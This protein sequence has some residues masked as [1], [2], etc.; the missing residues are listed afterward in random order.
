[1]PISKSIHIYI[2]DTRFIKVYMSDDAWTYHK[3]SRILRENVISKKSMTSRLKMMN[4][5]HGYNLYFSKR[6][7]AFGLCFAFFLSCGK[8]HIT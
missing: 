2:R 7:C 3:R 4:E 1:M 6:S 5:V 8:M